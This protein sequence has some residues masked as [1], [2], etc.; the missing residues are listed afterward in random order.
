MQFE[1]FEDCIKWWNKRK[2][3]GKAWRVKATGIVANNYNLDIKNPN[4]REDFEH[5]PPEQLVEDIMKKEQRIAEIM[6]EIKQ[7]L[8][9]GINS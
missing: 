3:N 8:N 9:R 4:S 5:L 2:E 7:V 1:E 6:F